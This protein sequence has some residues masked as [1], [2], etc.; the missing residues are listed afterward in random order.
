MAQT[1]KKWLELPNTA[2]YLLILSPALVNGFS[3]WNSI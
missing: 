2:L 3:N 1:A